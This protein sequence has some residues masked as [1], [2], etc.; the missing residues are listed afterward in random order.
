MAINEITY[1]NK[2]ALNENP[3]VQDI[4]KVKAVD[5]NEIK[6]IV[7]QNAN[8]MGDLTTLT[9]TSTD[10]IV[11]A[12]NN[13]VPSEIIDS[14][15]NQNAGYIKYSNGFMI[16]WQTKNI[17]TSV[18]SWGSTYYYDASMS[19]W[20]IPFTTILCSWTNSGHPQ[21]WSTGANPTTTNAGLI[22]VLRPN[23]ANYSMKIQIIALGLW[24]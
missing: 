10:S 14:S 8:L 19:N 21:F 13:L 22:R 18:Q 9:T 7:N 4:N 1:S 2:Q 12:I 15:L 5:M 11:N 17:T 20:V 23:E 3:N 16:Q 24:K 6:T